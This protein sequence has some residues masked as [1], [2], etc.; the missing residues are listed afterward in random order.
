V[1]DYVCDPKFCVPSP[2]FPVVVWPENQTSYYPPTEGFFN[3]A[4][5]AFGLSYD[6]FEA[7]LVIKEVNGTLTTITTGN[8]A[9]QTTITHWP[10]TET[11]TSST[12]SSST[13][14]AHGEWNKRYVADT[15]GSRLSKRDDTIVPAVC[16]DICNNAYLEA[17]SVGKTPALCDARSAF[18]NYYDGCQACIGAN[19][20]DV[21][22]VTK[23]Y[24]DPKFEQFLSYCASSPAQSQVTTTAPQ[25]QQTGTATVTTATQDTGNTNT[26]PSVIQTTTTTQPTTQT[27]QTTPTTQTTQTTQTGTGTTTGTDTGTTT[28]TGTTT[29]TGT[30]TSTGTSTGTGTGTSTGTGTGTGTG[31]TTT[32]ATA[33]LGG[34]S[35]SFTTSGTSSGSGSGTSSSATSASSTVVTAAAARF[36]SPMHPSSSLS[37]LFATVFA[38]LFFI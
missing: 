20:A 24:L 30:G 25:T 18:R 3:L 10:P 31:I 6:I 22:L 1:D 9:S 11:P 32:G 28:G 19:A 38:A 15:F 27:T 12:T 34:S 13:T 16:Y 29:S 17:Q 21:K 26:A 2:N 8:F 33:G 14:T 23:S 35:S 7:E 5:P 37:A 4:P 36:A